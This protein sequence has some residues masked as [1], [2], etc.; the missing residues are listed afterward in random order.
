MFCRWF[1]VTHKTTL[2]GWVLSF[3]TC[4]GAVLQLPNDLIQRIPDQYQH[5]HL[6][7]FIIS[8]IL[9]STDKTAHFSDCSLYKMKSFICIF[10]GHFMLICSHH[11]FGHWFFFC[12]YFIWWEF[13]LWWIIWCKW[14]NI[15]WEKIFVAI[16][17]FMHSCIHD[18]TLNM[19]S[20]RVCC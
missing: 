19:I 6:L 9:P 15:C 12:V 3:G 18:P 1:Y 16:C 7:H 8:S 5:G 17:L 14:F 20:I 13:C 2:P 10:I 11:Y 4:L